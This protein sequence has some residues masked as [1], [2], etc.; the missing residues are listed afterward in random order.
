MAVTV[1][2]FNHWGQIAAHIKPACQKAVHNTGAYIRDF[3]R[4]GAPMDTGFMAGNVYLSDMEENTYG[5]G[6]GP[7]KPS[8]WLLPEVAPSG[9]MEAVVGAAAQYSIYVNYG[10]H[11]RSGSWVPAQ[12]FWEPAVETGRPFLD[13]ELANVFPGITG[14]IGIEKL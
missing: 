11:T 8:Q 10:H 12:P 2:G 1:S 7:T 6:P 13:A 3:A 5:S 9:D 14:S 4:E